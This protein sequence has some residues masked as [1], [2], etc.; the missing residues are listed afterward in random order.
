MIPPIVILRGVEADG[1]MKPGLDG[2][3]KKK[4]GKIVNNRRADAAE[5]HDHA[6]AGRRIR[7]TRRGEPE[8]IS[9][10]SQNPT[11]SK[12]K[13]PATRMGPAG[14]KSPVDGQKCG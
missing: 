4:M 11:A 7:P 10:E 14:T 8:N 3:P 12:A 1:S 13:I 5:T 6:D 9:A 2:R